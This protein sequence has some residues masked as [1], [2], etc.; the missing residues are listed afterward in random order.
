D[1]TSGKASNVTSDSWFDEGPRWTS[2]G[3]I[4][5]M[6]TRGGNWSWGLFALRPDVHEIRE[7][8]AASAI[9]RR[10]PAVERDGTRWWLETD[11]CLGTTFVIRRPAGRTRERLTATQ[12]AKWFDASN[13]RMLLVTVAS[14]RTEYWAADFAAPF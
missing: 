14:R 12:G 11:G 2:D 10:F 4:V 8:E 6:S 1:L 9:E 3:E 13:G 5:F 7:V